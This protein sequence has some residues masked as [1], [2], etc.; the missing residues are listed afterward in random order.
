M[1]KFIRCLISDIFLLRIQ[2]ST[3]LLCV[4][5]GVSVQLGAVEK[6]SVKPNILFIMVDDLG[7]EWLSCYGSDV[8]K[9]PNIDN[10]AAEGMTFNNAYSMPSCTS[11]RTTLLTGKYPWRN[12]YVNH[13]DVPR[14]GVAYFD[15]KKK[16][17]T[18]FARLMK[19]LGYATYAAGK[20]QINDF[21]VEPQAMKKHGFDDWAMWTGSETGNEPSETRFYDAYVNTPE[22]SKTYAG[23]FGP[24]I[25]TDSLINFMG[26]HKKEPMCL[27]YPMALVHR[28]WVTTPDEPRVKSRLDRHKAMVR[29]ADKMVGKLIKSL[30]DLEIR[31]RTIVIF[32]TDN[33][34][35]GGR[36]GFTAT[37]NGVTVPGAKGELNEAGVCTPFIVNC[38]GMVPEG[39]ETDALTDFS[40]ILPT[41]L[42]LGGGEIPK[43]FV[44][45]GVS[46][47]SLILGEEKG[48][49][50]KWIMS[51]GGGAGRL[52]KDGVRGSEVF[53]ERVIRDK[54]YK[55]WVST[56]K[57]IVR[58]YDLQR[59]PW[60]KVNLL[61]GNPK[62]YKK[63]LQKFQAVVRALPNKDA[64]PIYEKRAANKWD[65]KLSSRK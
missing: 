41:F 9:T 44:T 32:T 25:Y 5:F 3:L 40:D 28:P 10:L 7:K 48:A 12:G 4:C 30:E 6:I 26:K 55:V 38:P 65:M 45:D 31:D 17:N 8:I 50:R 11:S 14:W 63:V 57:N 21:R 36:V 24:D 16:E 56:K 37:R 43:G 58:L 59:D 34:T 33:G 22:G 53:G 46:I 19:N 64:Y 23:K 39:V 52:T 35:T 61:E 27:Y 29:Y 42:E 13:W 60:E 54:H 49:K 51:L 62:E 20:W 47:A 2:I 15:W 18:T 1:K